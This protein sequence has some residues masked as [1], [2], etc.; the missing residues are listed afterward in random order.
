MTIT[1]TGIY[2]VIQRGRKVNQRICSIETKSVCDLPHGI[3]KA[4]QLPS[5]TK[6]IILITS[7]CEC[8]GNT[9]TSSYIFTSNNYRCIKC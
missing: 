8:D 1:V 2:L 6:K 7:E 5:I 3:I 4:N 9:R